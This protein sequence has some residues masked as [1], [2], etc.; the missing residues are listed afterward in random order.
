MGG[1]DLLSPGAVSTPGRMLLTSMRAAPGWTSLLVLTTAASTAIPLLVPAS[2]ARAVDAVLV[3]SSMAAPLAQVAGLVAATILVGVV[4]TW[5]STG[6]STGVI[7]ALR[8]SLAGRALLAGVTARRRIPAGDLTSRMVSGAS[9]ASGLMSACLGTASALLVSAGGLVALV[10]IDWRIAVAFVACVPVAVVL[11]RRFMSQVSELYARY[12]AAQGKLSARLVEALSGARTIQASGTR[13]REVER[14]LVPL[15]ELA[16]VGR[17]TWSSQQQAVWKLS[18]LTPLTEIV[19]LAVAGVGVSA[20]RVSPGEWIAVAGYVVIALG[21]L[22]VVDTLLELAHVRAGAVRLAEVLELPPGPDGARSAPAGPGTIVF[23]SVTV[24]ADDDLVLDQIDLTIPPGRMVAIV[25][26]S[27]AGK[28]TLAALAGGLLMPDAGAVLLDGIP[29]GELASQDLRRTVTYAFE[30]P[31][32]LGETVHE[33]IAYGSPGASRRAVE[34]AARS[35]SADGFIRR[36]PRGYD[37]PTAE[38]PFSGGEAQ[39]IGLARAV[40]GERRV[41]ILDDATSS[42]DTVTE[43]D[44]TATLTL[45]LSDRTRIVV[46]HRVN[47]AARADL[48]VWLADGRIRTVAAHAELWDEPAYRSLFGVVD[49]SQEGAT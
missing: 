24:R 35:V 15:P 34:L 20:G 21:F 46:A 39:R 44:V 42:L 40:L 45:G 37:T 33:A 2:L 7:V 47:T 36:L 25:G 8:T 31:A 23:R 48:V 13:A 29:L 19:V 17:A 26:H 10:L 9:E 16:A 32:M 6:A 28:S 1:P 12:Q 5:A 18:L 49:S 14:V 4:S 3:G 38:A 43:A 22:D 30:R 41:L 27:G 11:M